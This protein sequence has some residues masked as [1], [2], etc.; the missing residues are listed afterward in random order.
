MANP[1]VTVKRAREAK[2]A[3]VAEEIFWTRLAAEIWLET[4]TG[5]RKTVRSFKLGPR[6][7]PTIKYVARVYVR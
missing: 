4:Q 1:N 2:F 7:N 5:D 6:N 3:C